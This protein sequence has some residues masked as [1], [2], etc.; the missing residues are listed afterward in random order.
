MFCFKS[1]FNLNFF[2]LAV[3]KKQNLQKSSYSSSFM[4]MLPD[5]PDVIIEDEKPSDASEA[6]LSET[7]K[8]NLLNDSLESVRPKKEGGV[9]FATDVLEAEKAK[10]EAN[11]IAEETKATETAAAAAD[12]ASALMAASLPTA[13]IERE[14][15]PPLADDDYDVEVEE[16]PIDKSPGSIH[17]Q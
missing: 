15:S 4:T 14:E 17:I 5:S 2:Q 12:A 13:V 3:D 8:A 10:D 6:I 1:I 7:Q 9:A 16:K 11:R